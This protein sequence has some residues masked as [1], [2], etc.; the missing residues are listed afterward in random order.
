MR[1]TSTSRLKGLEGAAVS[2]HAQAAAECWLLLPCTED[3]QQYA[4]LVYRKSRERCRWHCRIHISTGGFSELYDAIRSSTPSECCIS[5]T[6]SP[7]SDP[8]IDICVS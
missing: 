5:G 3:V 4:Q 1:T 8:D 2:R 7:L 6:T